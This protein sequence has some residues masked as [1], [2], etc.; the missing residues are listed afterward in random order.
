[1]PYLREEKQAQR[2]I[3]VNT[4]EY[5]KHTRW[6]KLLQQKLHKTVANSSFNDCLNL[7]IC[8]IRQIWESP[9]G[10]REHFLII[11]VNETLQGWKCRLRL[12]TTIR[13][14]KSL[15][16]SLDWNLNGACQS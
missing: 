15:A 10:I 3:L 8:S 7:I 11:R 2:E 14:T 5:T 16:Q 9:A 12:D 13:L 4:S 1:M 6:G